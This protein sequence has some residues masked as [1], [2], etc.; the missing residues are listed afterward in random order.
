MFERNYFYFAKLCGYL[1]FKWPV[2]NM[3]RWAANHNSQ[4]F[5]YSFNFVGRNSFFSYTFPTNPPVPHGASHVD[6]MMYSWVWPFFS[7]PVGLNISE[8]LLSDKMIQMWTNFVIYGWVFI[9]RYIMW[10]RYFDKRSQREFLFKISD[11]TPASVS[12]LPGVPRFPQF[13]WPDDHYMAI[14]D[15]W[16]AEIHFT[17]T[18]TAT[19]N[20]QH[21][22]K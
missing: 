18:F 3:A 8:I 9:F 14:D 5:L 6:E 22:V 7:I 11:P 1:F 19:E 15:Q 2:Y 10:V 4:T 21:S 16:Q 17:N 13:S 12:F 20:D